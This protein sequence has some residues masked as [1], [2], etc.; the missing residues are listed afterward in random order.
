MQKF[1][2]IVNR[3]S[4][5]FARLSVLCL[6]TMTLLVSMN[7]IARYIFKNPISW[8]MEIN[9]YLFCGVTLFATAYSIK[10]D[11]HVRVDIIR[12]RL[13]KRLQNLLDFLAAPII[14]VVSCLL[15]W[16]GFSEAHLAYIYNKRSSSEVG[17]PLWPV[18]SVVAI[19]GI[20]S[21]LQTIVLCL[22]NMQN[23]LTRNRNKGEEIN[24]HKQQIS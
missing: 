13:N 14:L 22:E 18:W 12:V 21:F 5:W 7:V 23:F 1:N 11:A 6:L 3:I 24:P 2:Y 20:G 10:K 16:Y 4:L 8:A 15:I 17:T 9:Q 19:G